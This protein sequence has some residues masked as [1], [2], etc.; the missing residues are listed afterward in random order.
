M[1]KLATRIA[2]EG[3]MS[4][5]QRQACS[6][7]WVAGR[8][9]TVCGCTTVGNLVRRRGRNVPLKHRS[10]G[11]HA[12]ASTDWRRVAVPPR[13]TT[14]APWCGARIACMCGRVLQR[15]RMVEG[16]CG[17]AT[18]VRRSVRRD[19]LGSR[20]EAPSGKVGMVANAALTAPSIPGVGVEMCVRP[21]RRH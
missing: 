9:N 4:V 13:T 18:A 19:A 12:T 8:S 1:G 14:T 17:T 16:A 10:G 6:V 2:A 7:P 21:H 5:K 3:C 20:R 11:N 15:A